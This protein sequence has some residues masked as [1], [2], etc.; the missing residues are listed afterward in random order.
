MMSLMHQGK[1]PQY[2]YTQIVQHGNRVLK[3]NGL[4]RLSYA[5][6]EEVLSVQLL[7]NQIAPWKTWKLVIDGKEYAQKFKS[8]VQ[9]RKAMQ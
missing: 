9:W 8:E 2:K 6:R 5:D 4:E 7:L 1:F 3:A